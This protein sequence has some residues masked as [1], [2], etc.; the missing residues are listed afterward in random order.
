VHKYKPDLLY[1]DDDALPLWP[2]SDAG[3]KIAADFYNFNRRQHYGKLK[4]VILGKQLND[5]EKKCVVWDLERGAANRIEPLPWETDTCIGNWHYERAL[6]DRNRYKNARTVIHLLADIVS[7]NGNLLLNIPVRA[8]GTIDDKEETVL[9]GIAGWMDVNKEG[10]IGTRPW[11]VFGE[12]P[13]SA[14]PAGQAGNFTEGKG[15]PFTAEDVRFTVKGGTLYAILLG[16]P[17][18]DVEIKSLGTSAKLLDKP[19]RSLTLLGSPDKVH[20]TQTADALTI[21]APNKLPNDIAIVF[22]MSL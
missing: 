13:A 15:K 4:G 1:F 3:L 19:I 10:I 8:D 14:G 18:K 11:K 22:K 12:G 7:K 9:Q 20:W 2:V 6:Y 16:V 21:E 5:E 17:K